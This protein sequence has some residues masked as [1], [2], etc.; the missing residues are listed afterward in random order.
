MHAAQSRAG[1]GDPR[2]GAILALVLVAMVVLMVFA[3]GL[4]GLSSAAAMEASRS[5]GSVQAFWS[6]EA[7]IEQVKA[8]AQK[9]RR[10]FS[11]IPYGA[12][13]LYGSNVMSFTTSGGTV[14]VDVIDDPAW[15]NATAS[16]KRYV[17]RSRATANNGAK[18]TVT[19][20]SIIQSFAS[21]MHATHW[22]QGSGGGNIYFGTGDVIDGPVYVNDQLNILGSPR[23]LQDVSSAHSSVHYSSGGNSSVFEGGLNLNA[24]PLD[25]TG[26]FSAN[27]IDDIRQAAL[28]DGLVL[29]NN[30]QFNF[31]SNGT[32]TYARKTGGG[33]TNTISLSDINGAIYVDGD[34]YVNGVVNGQATVAASDAI[35]ISNTITYASATSPNPWSTN[36]NL[37]AVDDKLGLVASNQVQIISSNAFTDINIHAAI[38]VTG[39][40]GGFNA[41]YYT[42]VLGKPDINLFGSITQYRRGPVGQATTPWRGYAKNYKYDDRYKADS[43]PFFPYSLFEFSE[44]RQSTL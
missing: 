12:G 9:R 26:Q 33:P 27:Y 20:R 40:G 39:D 37:A 41:Q 8:I 15:T 28:D 32:L 2:E 4:F 17:I 21:Y 25:I 31:N 14:A 23:F 16:L 7:G 42:T 29:T 30:Y 1:R 6:A 43:P 35:Y 24:L 44:W 10:P 38:M 19:L 22:E 36:F 3:V 13:Y 18:Q 34:V 5:I 11:T